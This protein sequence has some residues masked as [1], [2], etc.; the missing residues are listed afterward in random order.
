MPSGSFELVLYGVNTGPFGA[1][2]SPCVESTGSSFTIR[3]YV[4]S[5]VTGIVVAHEA[6]WKVL[7]MGALAEENTPTAFT[8]TNEVEI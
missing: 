6:C 3:G 7:P 1:R 2:T 5:V 4:C 8:P